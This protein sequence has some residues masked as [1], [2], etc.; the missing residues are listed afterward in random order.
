ML[1]IHIATPR[2]GLQGAPVEWVKGGMEKALVYRHIGSLAFIELD[3]Q[4]KERGKPRGGSH[5]TCTLREGEE[6]MF[7]KFERWLL[8]ICHSQGLYGYNHS[9]CVMPF[10]LCDFFHDARYKLK[11]LFHN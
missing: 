8:S 9:V 10:L 5:L 4:T 1:V 6:F 2:E 7:M 11:G 3:G